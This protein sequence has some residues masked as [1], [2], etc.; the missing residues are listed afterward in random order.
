MSASSEVEKRPR[1]EELTE[2]ERK[3]VE[4][5]DSLDKGLYNL[6]AKIQMLVDNREEVDKSYEP[7][8]YY[9]LLKQIVQIEKTI[10]EI[11]AIGGHT[12]SEELKRITKLFDTLEEAISFPLEDTIMPYDTP[13]MKKDSLEFAQQYYS[14]PDM[15][16]ENIADGVTKGAFYLTFMFSERWF[17]IL[18]M[19]LRV[20][21]W[22][23]VI[24]MSP[25][26]TGW[27]YEDY[28]KALLNP[29]LRR[30]FIPVSLAGE[31]FDFDIHGEK[32]EKRQGWGHATSLFLTRPDGESKWT[33]IFIDSSRIAQA[34]LQTWKRREDFHSDDLRDFLNRYIRIPRGYVNKEMVVEKT[35]RRELLVRDIM[36]PIEEANSQLQKG[37]AQ[38]IVNPFKYQG[39]EKT[40]YDF[41]GFCAYYQAFN[42]FYYT[43]IAHYSALSTLPIMMTS[44]TPISVDIV[45]FGKFI[46]RVLRIFEK[47]GIKGLGKFSK[48]KIKG[49]GFEVSGADANEVY[50]KMLNVFIKWVESF[51]KE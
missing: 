22:N 46:V 16:Y 14:E 51:L 47:E 28:P 27:L 13:E 9:S 31:D 33:I 34:W 21:G 43:L 32:V 38:F 4:L 18:R 48:R 8:F 29:T 20:L 36:H 23:D 3:H 19:F 26:T 6:R 40:P 25:N 12:D 11:N 41:D 35:A 37:E 45:L 50:E 17:S 30:I 10:K 24:I 39:H 7:E 44:G 15:K 2:W 49:G 5:K 42:A 1:D